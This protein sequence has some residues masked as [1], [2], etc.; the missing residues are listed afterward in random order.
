MFNGD[1]GIIE[2]ID[3]VDQEVTVSR[4]GQISSLVSFIMGSRRK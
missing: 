2:H 3:L 1:I 4:S